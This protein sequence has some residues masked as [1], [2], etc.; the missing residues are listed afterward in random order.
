MAVFVTDIDET[1]RCN[2]C[3][4]V[5]PVPGAPQLLRA[6]ARLGVP[7][8]YLTAAPRSLYRD[9]NIAFLRDHA[10]PP[11]RLLHRPDRNRKPN[12]RFKTDVLAA[13]RRAFPGAQFLCLGDNET[14]DAI[15]YRRCHAGC[16]IRTV[17]AW[18]AGDN[19][20]A[21]PDPRRRELPGGVRDGYPAATRARILRHIQSLL[22]QGINLRSRLTT[23]A[24]PSGCA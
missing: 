23:R 2:R 22:R 5:R 18:V 20:P 4:P 15:A 7:V 6:V 13:L 14:G 1:L 3:A 24:S 9:V 10:F 17:R 11:G 16:Y 19:L 8:V 21:G 12:A